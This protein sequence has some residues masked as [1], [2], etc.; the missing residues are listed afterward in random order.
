MITNE[1]LRELLF[2]DENVYENLFGYDEEKF[3]KKMKFVRNQFE[4]CGKYDIPLIKK[5]EIDSDKIQLLGYTK[6][7]MNDNENKDKSIHFFM[8]DWKFD[9]V[10]DKPEKALEKLDQYYALLTPEFSM[11]YDMPLA[12]QID[13]VFKS[14]WCGAFWQSQGMLVIPTMLWGTER[15]YEFCFD[16]VE[17]GSVVAVSTY[18]RE[19]YKK[20]FMVGYNKMLE[21]VKPSAII[22]YGEPFEEM[23]GNIKYIDPFNKEELIKK[24]G[25]EKKKKKYLAGELYP[26]Y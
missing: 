16:G 20:D 24:I 23:E 4:R 18:A 6:T 14:R 12:R 11:Y 13:S 1:Q 3:L 19:P 5:Q 25:L 22:C 15:S 7:K 17:E 8:H 21:V 26:E 2:D 9:N 10:Y